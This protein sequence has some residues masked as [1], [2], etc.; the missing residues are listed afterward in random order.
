[1]HMHPFPTGVITLLL[2]KS[3]TTME[4][5]ESMRMSLLL[6]SQYQLQATMNSQTIAWN[7]LFHCMA[8]RLIFCNQRKRL[9]QKKNW[10]MCIQI[11]GH[12]YQLGQTPWKTMALAKLIL[13]Q[14][15]R[16][17]T[18]QLLI[19]LLTVLVNMTS[20]MTQ[21]THQLV[22]LRLRILWINYVLFLAFLLFI[23]Y[24]R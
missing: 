17:E 13:K 23:S 8:T 3:L 10:E 14:D 4:L 19:L 12:A 16:M 6:L 5:L 22:Q 18:S 11:W 21:K 2:M 7:Q 1:M 20:K 9:Q 15:M 24:V